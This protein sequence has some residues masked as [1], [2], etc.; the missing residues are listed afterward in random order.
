MGL[1]A[2]LRV[3]QLVRY[4]KGAD[5]ADPI[6]GG[7][8]NF[9]HFTRATKPG[10]ARVQ[11]ESGIS[12]PRAVARGDEIATPVVMIR[13]N[14][15]RAGSDATPWE[16]YFD[17]DRGHILYYGDSRA[18][19]SSDPAFKPGNKLLLSQVALYRAATR[20]ERLRAAP[21]LFFKGVRHQGQTKGYLRFEGYG[22]I[23]R[24]ERVTQLDARRNLSFANYRYDCVVMSLAAENERFHWSWINAR[25]D[26][27]VSLEQSNRHAPAAWRAWVDEGTRSLSR[28]RRSVAS[29]LVTDATEQQPEP[30]S[31]EEK[32]L[33]SIYAYYSTSNQTKARFEA[34]AEIVVEHVLRPNATRYFR[35]WITPPAGDG[36]A[37]FVARMDVGAGFSTSRIVLLGQAKCQQLDKA[38][39]G[40]DIARTVARLRRG[41]LGVFVT[42]SFF[43]KNT[44]VEVYDDE[45]PLVLIHG[46]QLAEATSQLMA[47]R[48]LADVNTFLGQVDLT[49]GA[50]IDVRNPSEIL[51]FT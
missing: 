23:Q 33:R 48:G 43:S 30:G 3:H 7:T 17:T 45:Y 38:T 50:R 41:W 21:L 44:Q 35:G 37:D 13:S 9:F 8:P 36:G 2:G 29:Q 11:M 5:P 40:R 51:F 46:R 39:S 6:T 27:A 28:V 19:D 10:M 24:T 14:P 47:E 25:R 32:L 18:G 12:R 49:Y 1:D 20:E 31:R 15:H 22:L 34:L 26:P 16:D 4:A 42:T